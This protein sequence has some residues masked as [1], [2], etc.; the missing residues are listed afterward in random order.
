M[1]IEKT[2]IRNK[3]DFEAKLHKLIY[4]NS[5]ALISMEIARLVKKFIKEIEECYFSD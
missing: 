3:A 4:D 5:N 1:K 2:K